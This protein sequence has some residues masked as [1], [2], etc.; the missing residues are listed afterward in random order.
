MDILSDAGSELLNEHSHPGH[1]D[2]TGAM[3]TLSG[4]GEGVD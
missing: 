2:V 3:A 1:R 4:V